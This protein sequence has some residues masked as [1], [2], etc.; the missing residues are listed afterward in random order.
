[1][2]KACD[3]DG[4]YRGQWRSDGAD[5]VPDEIVQIRMAQRVVRKPPLRER[6]QASGAV[7]LEH[8]IVLR[9]CACSIEAECQQRG[10]G[11][12]HD[13]ACNDRLDDGRPRL[14]LNWP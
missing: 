2:P 9:E 11:K 1:M 14:R 5:R 12:R 7:V 4:R 3:I 10:D 13:G 8:E 6:H